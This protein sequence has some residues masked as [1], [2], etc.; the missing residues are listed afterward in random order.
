VFISKLTIEDR[1]AAWAGLRLRGARA[2]TVA[3]EAGWCK[4]VPAAG[5]AAAGPK[6][7]WTLASAPGGVAQLEYLAPVASAVAL[8][9]RLQQLATAA[10]AAAQEPDRIFSRQPLYGTD[11]TEAELPQETGQL[12]HLSFTKGCY[13]GQEIVE[14]IRARGAVHRH[15]SAFHFAAAVG[16]GAGVEAN[17][18]PAGKLTSVAPLDSAACFA[19]GYVRDGQPGQAV[20]AAGIAG[21][22]LS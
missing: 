20:T 8:W 14:R 11:I 4:P 17:G 9:A 1:S 18:R 12:D 16:P 15:W 13:I 10:G 19:L 5:H 2:A 22:L 6:S 3:V 7:G 21:K